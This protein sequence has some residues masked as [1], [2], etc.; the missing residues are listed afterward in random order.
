MSRES[1]LEHGIEKGKRNLRSFEN[2][3]DEKNGR[4]L[5]K[6]P[7]FSFESKLTC[8]HGWDGWIRT[9]VM[10]ESKSCAL[11][12]LAT[13]QYFERKY[14]STFFAACQERNAAKSEKPAPR[15]FARYGF[16]FRSLRLRYRCPRSCP[17]CRRRKCGRKARHF[18]CFRSRFPQDRTRKG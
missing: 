11:T 4:N 8:H 16:S 12:D 1:K 3:R 10:Q 13:S 5:S 7:V 14:Y 9:S 6:S 17:S 15:I 18:R 2:K